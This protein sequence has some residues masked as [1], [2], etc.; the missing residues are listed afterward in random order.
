[1]TAERIGPASADGV[2]VERLGAADDKSGAQV[3]LVGDDEECVVVD[4][5]LDASPILEAVGRRRLTAV[6]CTDARPDRVA[7]VAELLEAHPRVRLGVHPADLALWDESHPDLQ[8]SLLLA[9]RDTVTV[10]DCELIVLHVPGRTPGSCCFHAPDLGVV[11]TGDTPPGDL[12]TSL[13]PDTVVH[14]AHGPSTTLGS[15]RS[16]HG[17]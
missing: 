10:G 14:P 17:S 5:S 16:R 8:P 9:D 3:W 7:S 1:M 12:P 11:F 2:R 6:L 4:A 15:P 13:V